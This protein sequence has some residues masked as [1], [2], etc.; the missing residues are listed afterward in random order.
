MVNNI[1][2]EI[3]KIEQKDSRACKVKYVAGDLGAI[4]SDRVFIS[5][6]SNWLYLTSKP[7]FNLVWFRIFFYCSVS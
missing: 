4:F 6:E 3:W 1:V 2:S 5:K 7:A